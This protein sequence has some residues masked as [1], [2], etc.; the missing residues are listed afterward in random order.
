MLA[1]DPTFEDHES[2]NEFHI[3]ITRD[4]IQT[5]SVLIRNQD[6]VRNNL[7]LRNADG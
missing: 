4:D 6:F 1:E 5:F 3:A 7:N 2:N